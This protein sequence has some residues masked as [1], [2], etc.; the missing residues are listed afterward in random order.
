MYQELFTA[1]QLEALRQE[2]E[3]I[4]DYLDQK[5]GTLLRLGS[6]IAELNKAIEMAVLSGGWG[7]PDKPLVTGN[8]SEGVGGVKTISC[9]KNLSL[10]CDDRVGIS[11]GTD[12]NVLAEETQILAA[13]ETM[14]L[15]CGKSEIRMT[16][17]GQISING[18]RIDLN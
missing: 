5:N 4:N 16:K 1:E 12:M 10:S 15:R 18:T 14:I 9:G 7:D 13:S 17:A 6:H 11:A 3:A 2:L 8:S